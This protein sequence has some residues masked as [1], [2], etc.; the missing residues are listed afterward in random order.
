MLT[1]TGQAMESVCACTGNG[2]PVEFDSVLNQTLDSALPLHRNVHASI[3]R[4]LSNSHMQHTVA[5]RNYH[6]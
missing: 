4:H 1:N 2:S 3:S 5:I 6:V